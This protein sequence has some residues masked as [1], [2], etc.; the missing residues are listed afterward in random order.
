MVT[1][2]DKPVI[3]FG[4]DA[5]VPGSTWQG[6]KQ[7]R[8]LHPV[9]VRANLSSRHRRASCKPSAERPPRGFHGRRALQREN[10][11]SNIQTKC[12]LLKSFRAEVCAKRASAARN[13]SL[14]SNR[15]VHLSS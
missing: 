6:V 15:A 7:G 10:R 3:A 9:A 1:R 14:N 2:Y 11:G 5:A 13:S 8:G 12:S 4:G